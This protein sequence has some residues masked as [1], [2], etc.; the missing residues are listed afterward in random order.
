M[1]QPLFF[2]SPTVLQKSFYFLALNFFSDQDEDM[3]FPTLPSIAKAFHQISTPF[4]NKPDSTAS[5]ESAAPTSVKGNVGFAFNRETGDPARNLYAPQMKYV[6]ATAARDEAT[7]QRLARDYNTELFGKITSSEPAAAGGSEAN[8]KRY[9]M[10]PIYLQAGKQFE[11]FLARSGFPVPKTVMKGKLTYAEDEA[12]R[13]RQVAFAELGWADAD[14]DMKRLS[15]RDIK[16]RLKGE[17]ELG[18]YKN[19]FNYA[20]AKLA[21]DVGALTELFAPTAENND[22]ELKLM[23][24]DE[25]SSFFERHFGIRLGEEVNDAARQAF[26][27]ALK[28]DK[29][30]GRQAGGNDYAGRGG[31]PASEVNRR[32]ALSMHLERLLGRL[33]LGT[34][35]KG[36]DSENLP[37]AKQGLFKLAES[38]ARERVV[39]ARVAEASGQNRF[40]VSGGSSFVVKGAA[41]DDFDFKLEQPYGQ[42]DFKP[43]T[44]ELRFREK[45]GRH[46]LEMRKV[47]MTESGSSAPEIL[48]LTG[49]LADNR[50]T[51]EQHFSKSDLALLF[52]SELDG[53][54]KGFSELFGRLKAKQMQDAKIEDVVFQHLD[55]EIKA[56][57]E[58]EGI[59]SIQ[60]TGY[61]YNKGLYGMDFLTDMRGPFNERVMKLLE[62]GQ[63]AATGSCGFQQD[64][65]YGKGGKIIA[66]PN[67]TGENYINSWHGN[68]PHE[69]LDRQ[70]THAIEPDTAR[71]AEY[72]AQLERSEFQPDELRLAKPGAPISQLQAKAVLK[73]P[74]TTDAAHRNLW[75]PREN[76]PLSV[77]VATVVVED[78]KPHTVIRNYQFTSKGGPV[79]ASAHLAPSHA[80]D[81]NGERVELLGGAFSEQNLKNF[82]ELHLSHE[83]PEGWV[84]RDDEHK[85]VL[86][87]E[88]GKPVRLLE[89]VVVKP[90]PRV[91][92]MR[93][94]D[95][96]EM[97]VKARDAENPEGVRT[98]RV[99]RYR[100]KK[101]GM[102]LFEK[103]D[104][105]G[106]PV[107]EFNRHGVLD[108][109]FVDAEGRPVEGEVEPELLHVMQQTEV[110]GFEIVGIER[111]VRQPIPDRSKPGTVKTRGDQVLC[112]YVKTVQSA[113]AGNLDASILRDHVFTTI[114]CVHSQNGLSTRA[115][116]DDMGTLDIVGHSYKAGD[117]PY[118]YDQIMATS[119]DRPQPH[120]VAVPRGVP[121]ERLV[122]EDV[123]FALGGG[124]GASASQPHRDM[125]NSN[126]SPYTLDEFKADIPEDQR[127]QRYG[128]KEAI[129]QGHA[130]KDLPSHRKALMEAAAES[131]QRRADFARDNIIVPLIRQFAGLDL[132]EATPWTRYEHSRS[133]ADLEALLDALNAIDHPLAKECATRLGYQKA[134]LEEANAAVNALHEHL[135]AVRA[136]SK[137]ALTALPQRASLDARMSQLA[138]MQGHLQVLLSRY[139]SSGSSDQPNMCSVAESLNAITEN[140]KNLETEIGKYCDGKATPSSAATDGTRAAPSVLKRALTQCRHAMAGLTVWERQPDTIRRELDQA[141]EALTREMGSDWDSSPLHPLLQGLVDGREGKALEHND[142]IAKRYHE[143]SGNLSHQL[144]ALRDLDDN[145]PEAFEASKKEINAALSQQL[146]TLHARKL[147]V[148]ALAG[149]DAFNLSEYVDI[150]K[151]I[152]WITAAQTAYRD[153]REMAASSYEARTARIADMEAELNALTEEFREA[154][155]QRLARRLEVLRTDAAAM[156]S[157]PGRSASSAAAHRVLEEE[158]AAIESARVAYAGAKANAMPDGSAPDAKQRARMASALDPWARK[159]DISIASN[160]GSQAELRDIEAFKA[161]QERIRLQRGRISAWKTFDQQVRAM[162]VPAKR[163]SASL[164]RTGK[165][166]PAEWLQAADA[167]GASDAAEAET[168]IQEVGEELLPQTLLTL[169]SEPPDEV[170][171]SRL[172]AICQQ[173]LDTGVFSGPLSAW[174]APEQQVDTLFRLLSNPLTPLLTGL[175]ETAETTSTQLHDSLAGLQYILDSAKS[176]RNKPAPSKPSDD[177]LGRNRFH[178]KYPQRGRAVP[179]AALAAM[180]MNA[181]VNAAFS[182]VKE[183]VNRFTGHVPEALE[184]GAGGAAVALDAV[185]GGITIA[186]GAAMAKDGVFKYRRLKPLQERY[187]ISLEE[188]KSIQGEIAD[189][190]REIAAEINGA[191]ERDAKAQ[192]QVLRKISTSFEPR[193]QTLEARL[194]RIDEELRRAAIDTLS[195]V[196]LAG[197][198]TSGLG[199]AIAN[200]A[201]TAGA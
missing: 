74:G 61:S 52:G 136:A 31:Q 1:E 137:E 148:T 60:G 129:A 75:T 112:T 6:L 66:I 199:G 122:A 19:L 116:D 15:K 18:K 23:T 162:E 36:S 53:G 201:G 2:C 192:E 22:V 21:L 27:E 14:P 180:A 26:D 42:R 72:E 96:V 90:T 100:D 104:E 111:W 165:V 140:F 134:Y 139:S 73:A 77:P 163:P 83:L 146:D 56:H 186:A 33:P 103:R 4:N 81:A 92:M 99:E 44:Y 106:D 183:A 189:M 173:L 151:E 59:T 82:R 171:D 101:T 168:D 102:D 170:R 17:R 161:Q 93:V 135:A 158:I 145:D 176:A 131:K 172:K 153:S 30:E 125:D 67:V 41:D 63:L 69:V 197:A 144:L 87:P 181:P 55:A 177:G 142:R 127:G 45:E 196:S 25:L 143:G 193:I 175:N 38:V 119:K 70:T 54:D 13:A 49:T 40:A 179:P 195:G 89:Q 43:C 84:L 58:R 46:E 3:K 64:L 128:N 187:R 71:A 79:I 191:S 120:P 88:T 107:R 7:S 156:A 37:V 12:L 95:T 133:S 160:G 35:P 47:H 24:P 174:Q 117:T 76:V 65:I 48:R 178:F 188:Y 5:K 169:L 154:I 80:I 185:P 9:A 182:V 57:F 118:E 115:V 62:S 200:L 8:I 194:R 32:K 109:V 39:Q 166:A 138:V 114:N 98:I 155:D 108:R 78:G 34:G 159:L 157:G 132:K 141:V 152:S 20:K 97:Q 11:A 126:V 184:I 150:R 29:A 91:R 113:K 198:G 130:L 51:L 94:P 68:D 10:E 164:I 167:S 86:D 85:V 105:F 28:K 16:T 124:T 123:A 50:A 110:P 190:H 147:G 121:R 149:T